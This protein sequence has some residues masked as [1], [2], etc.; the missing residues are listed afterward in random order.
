M[1]VAVQTASGAAI[2]PV[3]GDAARIAEV[4][5]R[6]AAAGARVDSPAVIRAAREGWDDLPVRLRRPVRQFRRNSGRGGLLLLRGLPVG[7]HTLPPTPMVS[8]SVQRGS[9]P[10]AALLLMI[11]SGL[12][13]PVAFRPEKSG[14]LVQDVVP[15]PGQEEFQGNA[16]SVLLTFHT[17]NA[18]HP[19]RPDYVLLLCLRA[20][21]EGVAGTRTAAIR[22]V[23]PMLGATTLEALRRPEF[24]TEA[25]PSFGTATVA[26]GPHPVLD[27]SPDDPDLQVDFAATRGLT[28]AAAEAL[29]EL[30]R[31]FERVAV[32]SRLQPGDLVVVDNH[33]T[34][35]GRSAFTPRYDGQDRWLQR[36]FVLASLRRSR[37]LRPGDG[38]VLV[39]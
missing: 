4:A 24:L 38:H 28:P 16:G 18:F 26:P 9:T 12:G 31:A 34:V 15:V 35:H 1:P 30:G 14:A 20:D 33:V 23:L 25:P 11:A 37:A 7:G 10:A 13:D 39:G 19:H 3:D 2:V 32:T 36:T 6:V 29:A 17:E 22:E 21:H 5:A 27:G 8:G